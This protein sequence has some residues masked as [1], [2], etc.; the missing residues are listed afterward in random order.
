MEVGFRVLGVQGL[1][2]RILRVCRQ[3][4]RGR[5]IFKSGFASA[6][7]HCKQGLGSRVQGFGFTLRVQ[8]PNIH[9]LTQNLYDDYYYQ[10]P[11][12]IST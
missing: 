8:V 3:S 7:S 10:N 11:N 5:E 9:I 12:F 4:P 2:F 6:F 1:R